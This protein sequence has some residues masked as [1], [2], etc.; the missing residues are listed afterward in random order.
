MYVLCAKEGSN[1]N[2]P[3]IEAIYNSLTHEQ[4]SIM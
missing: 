2:V 3:Q 1:L 4:L